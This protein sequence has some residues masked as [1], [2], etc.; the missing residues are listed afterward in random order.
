MGSYV[1]ISKGLSVCTSSWRRANSNA[2]PIRAKS[3]EPT[4]N[5]SLAVDDAHLSGF[6]EAI[7]LTDDGTV[8]EG[9]HATSS[10]CVMAAS[11]HPAVSED[12]LE[13]ITRKRPHRH[14]WQ[15]I[16]HGG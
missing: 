2:M 5:S 4:S 7:M 14:D 13:G 3:L 15:R 16:W 1:D 6:D 8:S 10:P 12:I 11:R 9:A